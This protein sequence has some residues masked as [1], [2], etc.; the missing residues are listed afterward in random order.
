MSPAPPSRA[1]GIS[2]AGELCHPLPLL[3][4]LLLA[5]NDGW[6]KGAHLLPTWLTGKLSDVAGLFFFPLLLAALMRGAAALF[7]R[8]AP[9][10]RPGTCHVVAIIATAAGFTAVKLWPAWNAVV[11]RIWGA[12]VMDRTDLW[13]LPVLALTSVYVA[14]RRGSAGRDQAPRRSHTLAAVGAA[15]LASLATSAVPRSHVVSHA[16]SYPAWTVVRGGAAHRGP[17]RLDLWV[18]KSGKEGLGVTVRLTNEGHALT[19]AFLVRARLLVE[20]SAPGVGGGEGARPRGGATGRSSAQGGAPVDWFASP[21]QVPPDGVRHLYLYF[22]F[23]NERAWNDG[24]NRAQLRLELDVNGVHQPAVVV[25][26][27]QRMC[28]HHRTEVTYFMGNPPWALDG[29]HERRVG[30]V[31]LQLANLVQHRQGMRVV[32]ELRRTAPAALELRSAELRV[33]DRR[34]TVAPRCVPLRREL[35]RLAL[36]FPVDFAAPT[37]PLD[38]ELRLVVRVGEPEQLLWFPLRVTTRPVAARRA[39]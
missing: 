11:G 22:H 2:W 39:R 19:Q 21:A 29:T 10:P 34:Y 32:L 26:L 27:E 6:L 18:A 4:V 1:E 3:A 38:G 25:D 7:G 24:R 17:L 23:D 37:G 20:R 9:A 12:M 15:A 8:A 28:G 16:R 14:W 33:G 5:V 30:P 31:T 35:E 13:A 36:E